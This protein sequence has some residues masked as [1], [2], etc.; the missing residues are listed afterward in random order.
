MSFLRASPISKRSS[1]SVWLRHMA[2]VAAIVAVLF[3]ATG[4]SLW[5]VDAPG[6][7]ATCPVCH[8]AHISVLPGMPVG[9]LATPTLVAWLVPAEARVAHAAPARLASPPRGPPSK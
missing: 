1:S 7:A 8:L 9:G 5:H 4:A 3:V 2:L 6:S